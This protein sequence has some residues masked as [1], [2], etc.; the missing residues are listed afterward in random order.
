MEYITYAKGIRG[1]KGDILLQL[2]NGKI[3]FLRG[4]VP[5]E[6]EWYLVEIL[7]NRERYAIVRLHKHLV[8]N[9]IGMCLLCKRVVDKEKLERFV[10]QWWGNMIRDAERLERIGEIKGFL[11]QRIGE[12]K[13]EVGDM[14]YRLER[15]RE[16]KA[17]YICP[18][19]YGV[20][21]SCFSYYC[22]GKVCEQIDYLISYLRGIRDELDKRFERVRSIVEADG[23]ITI[24]TLG[25]RMVNLI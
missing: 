6:G 18:P 13:I 16:M 4:F 25:I 17:E 12:L 5:N 7:E 19:G 3:A 8:S 2:E 22:T 1:K 9:D 14:I 24:D 10:Q 15:R 11:I 23:I 21:D 20:V